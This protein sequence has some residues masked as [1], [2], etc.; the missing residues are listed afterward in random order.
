MEAP[1]VQRWA[2]I[3]SIIPGVQVDEEGTL[4][5]IVLKP[6]VEAGMLVVMGVGLTIFLLVI[7]PALVVARKAAAVVAAAAITPQ[8]IL[9]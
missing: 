1:A 4:R 3:S 9:A 7:M 6:E 5:N 8:C 2:A